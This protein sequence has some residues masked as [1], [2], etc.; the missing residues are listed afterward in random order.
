M[1]VCV[2]VYV[3][4]NRAVSFEQHELLSNACSVTYNVHYTFT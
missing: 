4:V 3:F 1:C 2:W